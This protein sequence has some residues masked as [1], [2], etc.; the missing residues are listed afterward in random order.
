MEIQKTELEEFLNSLIP[1]WRRKLQL[2]QLNQLQEQ[3]A[4]ALN[5]MVMSYEFLK[6]EKGCEET[7]QLSFCC[8]IPLNILE[9]T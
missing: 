5:E 7:S 2:T 8:Y 6:M 3:N 4:G 9:E 1:G